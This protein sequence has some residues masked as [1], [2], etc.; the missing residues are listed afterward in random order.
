MRAQRSDM[1]GRRAMG[2]VAAWLSGAAW[3]ECAGGANA[4]WLPPHWPIERLGL[5]DAQHT[6]PTGYQSTL[7]TSAGGASMAG[8]WVIGGSQRFEGGGETSGWVWS[9]GVGTVRLGFTDAQHTSSAG[10]Q[11]GSATGVTSEGVVIG[12]STR[13]TGAANSGSTAW[14]WSGAT[15]LTELG[16]SGADYVRADGY[17]ASRAL[18]IAEGG[19]IVGES[20]RYC[21]SANAGTAAWAWE[22]GSGLTR[23]GFF[24]A[25][26]TT[27]NAC[28]GRQY[29]R[30]AGMSP[31]GVVAGSSDQALIFALYGRSAWVWDRAHGSRR[32]GLFDAEHTSMI[33]TGPPFQFSDSRGVGA[34]GETFGVSRR[35]TSGGAHAGE[36]AWVWQETSGTSRVGLTDAEHTTA[37]FPL[38]QNSG[39]IGVVSGRAFGHSQRFAGGS[40]ARGQTAWTWTS[41]GGHTVIGDTDAEHTRVS[42]GARTSAVIAVSAAGAAMGYSDR[43]GVVGA[44][45]GYAGRDAWVWSEAGGLRRLSVIDAA[46]TRTDGYRASAPS[47]INVAGQVVGYAERYDGDTPRGQSAWFYDPA[48]DVRTPLDFP[49]GGAAPAQSALAFTEAAVLTARG[50]VAGIYK[51]FNGAQLIAKRVFLWT[52]AKGF[53]DLGDLVEGGAASQGWGIMSAVTGVLEAPGP[54]ADGPSPSRLAGVVGIGGYTGGGAMNDGMFAVLA[55]PPCRADANGDGAVDFLDLNIVLSEYGQ[56]GAP[57]TLAADFNN[58][59]RVDFLDLNIALGEFGRVC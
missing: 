12:D 41:A 53:T 8:L 19:L 2:V 46:H 31:G 18:L 52:L 42:D 7:P 35:F 10:K 22:T 51:I 36:S 21:G 20:D 29:S 43:Y 32:V 1:R 5:L 28:G 14:R 40:E 50:E 39:V 9:P 13:Y 30:I 58:D 45:S 33:L 26:H 27:P 57:G 38:Y 24:D 23:I 25:M 17:R 49:V 6:S 3:V 54:S 16:F 59:G 11:A 15:G 4:Q 44:P 55:P 34:T 48:T 56:T 47:A 37:I